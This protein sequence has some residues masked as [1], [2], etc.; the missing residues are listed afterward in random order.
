MVIAK[1]LKSFGIGDLNLLVEKI[2][3]A[4][5]QFAR[6]L[7]SWFGFENFMIFESLDLEGANH[8]RR[9]LKTAGHDK[10]RFR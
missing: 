3:T 10:C 9:L 1:G 6:S 2:A 5:D 8:G 7:R 4:A